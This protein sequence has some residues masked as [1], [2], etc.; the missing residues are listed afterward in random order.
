MSDV[1]DRVVRI[2]SSI[3]RAHV[4]TYGDVAR[5]SG[6]GARAVGQILRR[7]GHDAPWW[8]VVDAAGRPVGA[9]ARTARAR[10]VDEATPLVEG[11]GDV[12]VDLPRAIWRY[13]P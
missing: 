12:R 4:L 6:T 7:N 11:D 2:V 13:D 3:P 10:F 9:L 8:R 1:A 5:I